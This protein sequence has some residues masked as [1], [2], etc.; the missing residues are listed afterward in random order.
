VL[1]SIFTESIKK[2]QI[3]MPSKGDKSMHTKH[4]LATALGF[5]LMLCA[6][7]DAQAPSAPSKSTT[8]SKVGGAIGSGLN[9]ALSS[10]FPGLSSIFKLIW[11]NGSN[12]KVSQTQAKTAT[13]NLQA[14]SSQGLQNVKAIAAELDTVTLF[15]ASCMSAENN[16]VQLRTFLKGKTGPLSDADLLSAR[17]LWTKAQAGVVALKDTNAIITKLGDP[18]MQSIFRAVADE[19]NGSIANISDELSSKAPNAMS[20]LSDDLATL[21]SQL[22]AVTGLSGEIIA[23]VSAALDKVATDNLNP[24]AAKGNAQLKVNQGAI[25]MFDTVLTQHY[26]KIQ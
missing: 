11:P 8:A 18:T 10:A 21:D 7:V 6:N 1:I 16:V 22:A 20:L 5:S 2:R 17:H 15:L 19:N 26:K 14:Q 9:A 4:I 25:R 3:P 23:N 12:S 24:G 13:S